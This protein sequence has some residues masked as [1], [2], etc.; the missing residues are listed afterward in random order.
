MKMQI[1]KRAALSSTRPRAHPLATPPALRHLRAMTYRLD[2]FLIRVSGP[3]AVSF[4]D[5][6]ATQ[7]LGKLDP[8]PC[9][10]AGLLTPQGKLFADMIVWRDGDG[11][12]LETDPARG[13][14]L[15]QKL[16]MHKLRANVMLADISSELGVIWGE[17]EDDPR[18]AALGKRR[19][20][21]REEVQNLHDGCA[22]FAAKMLENGV[23]DPVRGGALDDA[24]AL[25]ALFEELNGVDFQ[26]G[27]FLGQENVSRMKR[28]ATTRKK[29]CPVVFDSSAPAYGTPVKA[30]E[31]EIGTIRSGAAGR[32]MAFLRLDRALAASAPL[33][34]GEKNIRLDPPAWLILPA[35]DQAGD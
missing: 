21:P 23:P 12:V 32:A 16:T 2:R 34:A 31:A 27:C 5:A 6:L 15:L 30:G 26:K 22:A 33:T 11:L 1:W 17:G 28:R 20:A 25:E 19:L 9:A 4:L 35:A 7:N 18:L 10:Y 14:A 3:D 13:P 24:F 29:F 8:A